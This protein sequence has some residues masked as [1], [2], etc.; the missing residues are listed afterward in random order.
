M[1]LTTS[2]DAT[3]VPQSNNTRRERRNSRERTEGSTYKDVATKAVYQEADVKKDM[4]PSVSMTVVGE[5]VE[6]TQHFHF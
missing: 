5:N 4:G 3:N 6:F 1:K 2:M